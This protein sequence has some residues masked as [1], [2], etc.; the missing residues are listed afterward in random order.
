M[1]QICINKSKSVTTPVQRLEHL[2]FVLCSRSMTIS[3]GENKVKLVKET[4]HMVLTCKDVSIRA[5]AQLIG[6]FVSCFPGVEYGPLFYRRLEHDK[7][8]ALKSQCGNF[9]AH[10]TLTQGA[11]D[12][13][14]W[15]IKNVGSCPKLISH[16]NPDIILQTDASSS[17]WG[18]KLVHGKS[19]GGRWAVPEMSLHINELETKAALLGLQ[20]LCLNVSNSH[21]QLQ[22]DNTTAVAYIREMGGSHS[23]LCNAATFDIW[24]WCRQRNIWLSAAHIPGIDNTEADRKSRLF[25]DAT[26]WKLNYQAFQLCTA[27][28]GL[29]DIDLFSSRL[30][31]QLKSYISWHPD[32]GAVAV[33]AFS[34]S[35]SNIFGYA[36]P[37]FRL[38]PRVLRKVEEDGAKVIVIATEWPT[39]PWYPRITQ[40]SIAPPILLP[41]SKALLSLP[42]EP[43]RVHPLYPKLHLKAFLLLGK[44]SRH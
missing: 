31:C 4:G 38:L 40:M 9:D 11:K 25:N 42:W 44:G 5:V 1:E 30:N 22:M 19:A 3:L 41:N 28:W 35:W 36:F 20:A 24:N 2:G 12:D 10:M 8:M 6:R 7:S 34:L 17:G 14:E 21:I 23:I 16:G 33:D 39:Q 26:E 13:I 27:Q 43:S 15:W 29:P 18:A 37:P 32:P